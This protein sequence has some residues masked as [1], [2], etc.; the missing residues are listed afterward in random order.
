MDGGWYSLLRDAVADLHINVRTTAPRPVD[1]PR[2]QLIT[3]IAILSGDHS[4]LIEVKEPYTTDT[5]GCLRGISPCLSDGAI[6]ITVD[7]HDYDELLSPTEGMHVTDG[8]ELSSANLPAECHEFNQ[9]VARESLKKSNISASRRL[10]EVTFEEWIL[11]MADMAVPGRCMKFIREHSL[12]DVQSNQSIFRIVT[13]AAIVRLSSGVGHM[14]E[15]TNGDGRVVVPEMEFWE[16][17]V[18]VTGI[19][20][21]H[22]NLSGLLGETSRVLYDKHNEPVMKGM[23]A[24]HGTVEDY[25][26]SDPLA[27]DFA[28]LYKTFD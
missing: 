16:M 8:I 5:D 2:N 17:G 19:A 11:S 7:G 20:L 27:T 4:I 13:P 6:R 24:I 28:L 22:D 21:Q 3:A 26:V 1:F 9:R 14:N 15:V 12:H 10:K 23:K 18:G 25:R